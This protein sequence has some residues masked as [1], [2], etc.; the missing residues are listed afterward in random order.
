MGF[1]FLNASTGSGSSSTRVSECQFDMFRCLLT[2]S[3][4]KMGRVANA[5]RETKC[6][7]IVSEDK[8]ESEDRAMLDHTSSAASFWC[9]LDSLS[10]LPT[11]SAGELNVLR[12]DGYALGV[13][14]AQVGVLEETDQVCLRRLLEGLDGGD[15]EAELVLEGLRD[16]ADEAFEGFFAD[17]ELR[18]PLVAADLAE[19]DGA[20]SPAV[21]LPRLIKLTKPYLLARGLATCGLASCLLCTSH[22]C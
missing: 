8:A 1:D 10:A 4:Q 15:L 2:Q 18:G 12:H 19:G 7:K 20:R 22:V 3:G 14:G 13:D 6:E 16:F 11:D 21:G 5:K 17:Q 9:A